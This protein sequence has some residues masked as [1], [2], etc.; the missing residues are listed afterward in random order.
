VYKRQKLFPRYS[1][2]R[3]EYIGARILAGQTDAYGTRK[4]VADELE[5]LLMMRRPSPLIWHEALA[6]MRS[7]AKLS[8]EQAARL[9]KAIAPLARPDLDQKA[10]AGR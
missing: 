6:W 10:L 7:E 9:E 2:L 4:S 1:Q 3:A 8:K 5:D